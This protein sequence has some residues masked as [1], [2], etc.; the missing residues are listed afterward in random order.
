MR[1]R[2]GGA[3]DAQAGLL[4]RAEVFLR[5]VVSM[6]LNVI[7]TREMRCKNASQR[8]ATYDADSY[9]HNTSARRSEVFGHSYVCRARCKTL[10]A[11]DN[12]IPADMDTTP[13][14]ANGGITFALGNLRFG[15]T[16]AWL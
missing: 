15:E 14:A 5:D 10:R 7:K 1:L 11:A 3:T 6:H 13:T 16:G 8:A 4:D 9:R 12:N 2:I